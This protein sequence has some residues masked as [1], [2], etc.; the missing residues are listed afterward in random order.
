[1]LS[2]SSK[3][4]ITTAG[5]GRQVNIME[6][7]DDDKVAENFITWDALKSIICNNIDYYKS[8]DTAN[9][10]KLHGALLE[11]IDQID[12]ARPLYREIE[13]FC[14]EYDLDEQ[15]QA[16]GYRSFLKVFDSAINHTFKILK[17]VTENRSGLLF[18]KT[19]Y[20]K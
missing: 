11:I 9:G 7:H 10:L 6:K 17:Y 12:G 5:G 4:N 2:G 18:R 16:N 20:T 8:D 3:L 1:L 13:S 19:A 14:S 15:T